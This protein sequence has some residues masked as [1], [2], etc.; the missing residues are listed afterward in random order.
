MAVSDSV[1]LSLLG[2]PP[3][4]QLVLPLAPAAPYSL[5]YLV[6]HSGIAEACHML[7]HA[8]NDVLNNASIFRMIHIL[9]PRGAGKTHVL[10]AY[11]CYAREMGVNDEK[12]TFWD[13]W[14][15]LY[16]HGEGDPVGCFV[17]RYQNHKNQ[18]GLMV[19]SSRLE[20]QEQLGDPHLRSRLLSGL[21]LKLHYPQVEELR[22]LVLSILERRNIRLRESTMEELL[23]FVPSN[24]LSCSQIFARVEKLIAS[25]NLR[26]NSRNIERCLKEEIANAISRR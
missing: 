8:I 6:T 18:G 3:P 24:P 21:V 13:D 4:Q 25:R 15:P 14:S 19:I 1:Q 22:P 20:Q 7:A 12:L 2:P 26:H 9:G 23:A 11:E 16:V 10:R 5:S 17:S